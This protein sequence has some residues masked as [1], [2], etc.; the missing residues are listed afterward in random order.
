MT[1]AAVLERPAATGGT[2][3]TAFEQRCAW[4]VRY[5][6]DLHTRCFLDEDHLDH[7]TT[8]HQGRGRVDERFRMV[9]WQ[10]GDR[11]QYRTA[12]TDEYAWQTGV[13]NS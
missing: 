8:M 1:S 9:A 13:A 7:Q 3:E 6:P 10:H 12:R 5:Q 4:A 2:T 11:R